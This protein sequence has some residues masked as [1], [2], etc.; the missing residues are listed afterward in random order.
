M[1]LLCNVIWLVCGGLVSGLL[2][3]VW[4]VIAALTIVGLPWSSA[5]FRL[6]RFT[7]W[8]FGRMLLD[9]RLVTGQ[10]DIGTGCLGLLGNIVWFLVAGWTLCLAHL[11][12]AL[13][14]AVT[15]IGIPFAFQHLKLAVACLAPIGT[16]VVEI[17]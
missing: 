3:Y 6:G 16:E 5:C 8:P 17:P 12:L 4:G 14:C 7:M 1:R 2:W 13:A 11:A 10:S 9:R 15:L